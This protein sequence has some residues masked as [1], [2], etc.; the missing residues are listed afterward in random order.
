MLES[1]LPAVGTTGDFKVV[2]SI[3]YM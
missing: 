3:T 1:R 2:P